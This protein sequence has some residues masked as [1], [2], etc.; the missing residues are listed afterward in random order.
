MSGSNALAAAKRRRGGSQDLSK[1]PPPPGSRGLQKGTQQSQQTPPPQMN[2]LQLVMINHH[3]LNSLQSELPKAIDSLGESLNSLSSNCDYLHENFKTLQDDVGLLKS[4]KGV[5]AVNS[6]LENK[7]NKLEVD[8]SE[9]HKVVLKTQSFS[10]DLSSQLMKLK[11]DYNSL[12]VALNKRIEA[13]ESSVALSQNMF[14]EKLV[15]L[16]QEKQAMFDELS[17]KLKQAIEIMQ[18][19]ENQSNHVENVEPEDVE[20]V[21]HV[22]DVDNNQDPVV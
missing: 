8:I 10:M 11:E 22:E 1:G 13:L 20:H 15:E 4:S 9:S 21:E 17:N 7:L 12:S 2:P 6:E 19:V 3:R 5:N 14:N 16:N 18:H